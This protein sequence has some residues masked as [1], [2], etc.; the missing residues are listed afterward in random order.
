MYGY[1]K[2]YYEENGNLNVPYQYHT[3]SGLNLYGWLVNRRA[4]YQAGKLK[5][6]REKTL[7]ALGVI[8]E[9]KDPWYIRYSLVR[10][11]FDKHGSISDMPADYESN[12]IQIHN[13]LNSQKQIIY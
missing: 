8:W 3:S 7:S 11:Y 9:K 6:E 4:E 13:W 10:E 2:K 12:G 1:A 5:P